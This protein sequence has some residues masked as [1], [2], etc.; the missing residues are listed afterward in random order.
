[1]RK[2]FR[3]LI[4]DEQR[5]LKQLWRQHDADVERWFPTRP[6]SSSCAEDTCARADAC[7]HTTEPGH[8]VTHGPARLTPVKALQR[9]ALKIIEHWESGYGSRYNTTRRDALAI[10][11]VCDTYDDAIIG[12]ERENDAKPTIIATSARRATGRAS[13]AQMRD[14][15]HRETRPCLILFGTGWGL[16]EAILSQSDYVL[17]PIEG[18]GGYNHLSVRSAAAIVLDRLLGPERKEE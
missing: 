5:R 13:F 7:A 10:A 6:S 16:T 11:R 17:E 15:L 12:I 3:L 8:H 1:M 4:H 14:M 2:V 9:L 18:R